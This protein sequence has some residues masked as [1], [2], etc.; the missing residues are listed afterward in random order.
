M[1]SYLATNRN[2]IILETLHGA[3]IPDNTD[4]FRSSYSHSFEITIEYECEYS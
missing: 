2:F 3:T 4:N 1:Q